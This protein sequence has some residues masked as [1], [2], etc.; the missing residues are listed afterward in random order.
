MLTTFLETYFFEN[1][2]SKQNA[3]ETQKDFETLIYWSWI[4]KKLVSDE[5]S[6]VVFFHFESNRNLNVTIVLVKKILKAA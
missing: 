2:K 5:R 1:F 4:S 6:V 3:I